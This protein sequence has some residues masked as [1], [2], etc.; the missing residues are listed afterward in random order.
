[1]ATYLLTIVIANVYATSYFVQE[2]TKY[3][4]EHYALNILYIFAYHA[5]LSFLH[6]YIFHR[7]RNVR[8][9]III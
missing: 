7:C 2:N 1:M 9:L 3:Y 6:F 4:N 8:S 5:F